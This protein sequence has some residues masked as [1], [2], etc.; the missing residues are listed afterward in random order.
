MKENILKILELDKKAREQ[1]LAAQKKADEIDESIPVKIREMTE[2]Q[3]A[4]A[5][6]RIADMEEKAKAD[7]Q[8]EIDQQQKLFEERLAG[9]NDKYEQCADEWKKHL[10]EKVTEL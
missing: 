10:I 2:K 6:K 1:T 8:K 4:R 3:N 7:V 9:L 5:E